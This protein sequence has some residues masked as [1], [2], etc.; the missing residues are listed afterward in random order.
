[1]DVA[2]NVLHIMLNM[3]VPFFSNLVVVRNWFPGC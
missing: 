2:V 3:A 1:M